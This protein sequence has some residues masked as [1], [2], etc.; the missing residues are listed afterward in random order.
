MPDTQTV[1]IVRRWGAHQPGETVQ[2]DQKMADWL[3]DMSYGEADGQPH[4]AR[5]AAPGTDGPDPRAGGDVTR[6]RMAGEVKGS[7][8]GERARGVDGRPKPVGD[9]THVAQENRGAKGSVEVDERGARYLDDDGKTTWTSPHAT[10]GLQ[11]RVAEQGESTD[12]K[13]GSARQASGKP[14]PDATDGEDGPPASGESQPAGRRL[15]QPKK[16]GK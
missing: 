6:H 15:T 8:D 13:A 7:R 4:N 11:R 1:K 10:A 2:V 16:A 5:A 3:R 9:V 12:A 14:T